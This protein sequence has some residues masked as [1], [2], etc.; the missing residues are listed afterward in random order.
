MPSSGNNPSDKWDKRT[1]LPLTSTNVPSVP[2]WQSTTR[3][4]GMVKELKCCWYCNQ[5]V[6][7]DDWDEINIDGA[8]EPELEACREIIENSLPGPG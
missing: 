5:P 4:E 2:F 8:L 1:V 3:G 7:E 6:S